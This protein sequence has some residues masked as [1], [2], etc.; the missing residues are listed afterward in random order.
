[1]NTL[2]PLTFKPLF[3]DKLWGGQ[4]IKQ[5]LGLNTGSLPNCGEAWLLSGVDGNPTI[6]ANGYLAGNELNELCEVFMGDLLGEKVYERFGG[7]FPILVKV[8][9]SN[10]WLSIQV[11]PD[12]ALAQQR[13][14]GYGKTEMW[15]AMQADE[16]AR[17][18]CGFNRPMDQPTY[19]E[20]L[21]SG[22]L[23]EIMNYEQVEQGDVFYIP[24]GRVH[25]LG[26]GLLIAEIQQ[27]SDITYRIY[28]WD[29]VDDKGNPRELHTDLALEA[30][31]F[32]MHT[33]YKTPYNKTENKPQQLVRSPFFTTNLLK[34]LSPVHT[35]YDGLDS[36]V[37]L[38]C[39]SG[40]CRISGEGQVI[41]LKSGEV[42]LL[43]N[44]AK[45]V[46][47]Y[48]ENECVILEVYIE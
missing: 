22:K 16:G 43:P 44:L 27:T 9:D 12:D 1:M 39:S 45:Q 17:L 40:A 34:L 13:G 42:V 23:P 8:I 37:I 48:P 15:Y 2:Y 35:N 46:S 25:A 31:D 11:H 10:D 41:N 47:I 30:I 26:P 28:D 18:I 38:M 7:Q 32:T 14:S 21:N 33:Q 4:K 5:H 6:I 36:F 20:Y 29:R 3:K 24:A 19:L